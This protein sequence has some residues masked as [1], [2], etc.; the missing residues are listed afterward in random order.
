MNDLG[1]L[2]STP[3]PGDEPD[4]P[5]WGVLELNRGIEAAL[6]N[7]FPGEIWLRGEIQGLSR[8]RMRKHW[9]FELV[10]KDPRSDQVLARVSV[11]LLQWN[12]SKV[13][14]DMRAAPGFELEDDIEVR[15]RCEMGYYPPWGKLQLVMTGIDPAFTLG[16]M[17]A[18]RERI[19]QALARD[20]LI[21]RN[22]QHELPAFPHRIGLVTS[23][24]SAA[25]NDFVD[26][27]RRSGLGLRVL[28]CDARVQGADTERTVI[29]A[30][31]TLVR[32]GCDV[33]VLA[34]GGGSRSDL[35]GFDSEAIARSIA[36]MPVPV[37][38]GIGHEIDTSVADAVAH[39]SLKTP[40]ATAAFLVERA[41]GFVDSLE[42]Q[43][44]AIVDIARERVRVESRR[45]LDTA[46]HLSRGARSGLSLRHGQL[47]T[48]QR[49][50]QRE[51]RRSLGRRL[52]ELGHVL[53]RAGHLV[54]LRLA[55][56][57]AA[58]L[59][60]A[61]RLEPARARRPLARRAAE[62]TTATRGLRRHALRPLDERQRA[63]EHA[64]LTVRALDPRRVLERGYSLTYDE[65]G[66]LLR[67]T[68]GVS[69]GQVLRTVLAE[70]EIDT[71]VEALRPDVHP[72][73]ETA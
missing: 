43:Y 2:F 35:A 52:D 49:D 32:R 64:A 40:T 3:P 29:A 12:R 24:G 11:A 31:H 17:A 23:V 20:G 10:E 47:D 71:R 8:T 14:R 55:E 73:E 13:Q 46:R 36:R 4:D 34:R 37:L 1:P 9:Y 21:D 33:V 69:V 39:T 18:N 61:R 26:E 15:V 63:L 67:S 51:S 19:L 25:Y 7:A 59:H 54:R 58:I 72:D 16:Q 60:A 62:L 38:T 22:A 30:M 42:E 27:I 65:R 5:T 45:L 48:I 44:E 66:R 56:R 57:E 6:Q 68:G 53:K 28:A 50:L 41:Q 70:G